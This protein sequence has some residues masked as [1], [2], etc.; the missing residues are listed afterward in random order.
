M[1]NVAQQMIEQTIVSLARQMEQQVD[2]ELNKLDN[3][4]EDDIEAIRQKRMVELKHRQA[5]MKD[6]V[7]RGHGE[8]REIFTEAEFFKEMKGEDKMICHFFRESNFPCQ[9][10]DK[11]LAILAKKHLET[12]FV[13]INAEKS[14]FLTDRLKIWM[15]PTLALI[16]NEKT[17][18]Y[19]VGLD[20]LGGKDDFETSVLAERLAKS[21]MIE[22]DWS[23]GG[24]AAAAA[25]KG[26]RKGGGGK[27]AAGYK[28][29]ESDED[30]D[31]DE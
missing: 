4:G 26:I 3:L 2:R 15:L 13:K 11:H 20:Q 28:R 1:A 27:K 23:H 6:W 7:A 31:F 21:D 5:K 10:M 30:S 9:V 14:P 19:V 24:K 17:M 25:P 8:Y 18:D 29:T 16:R 12:K 22:Y